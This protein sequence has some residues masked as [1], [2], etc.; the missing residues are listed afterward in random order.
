MNDLRSRPKGR[1]VLEADWQELYILTENLKA[2]LLFYKDDLRFL[3]HLIDKYFLWMSKKENID[4]VRD[5]E[6]NLMETS[7]QCI[8]L[9]KRTS[10]HLIHLANLIDDAFKYDSHKLR[11]EHESL[12]DDIANF[13]KAFRAN[14]KDILAITEY[15][16]DNE[17]FVEQI[18]NKK[19]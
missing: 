14:R 8:S 13:V 2:D 9:L 11:E 4:K 1:Y 16:I 12:E 10:I 6:V 3:Q 17:K 5:V 15:V 19:K 18:M 7:A